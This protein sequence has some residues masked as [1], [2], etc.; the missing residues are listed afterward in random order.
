MSSQTFLAKTLFGI[1]PYLTEEL[2]RLGAREVTPLNRAVSFYGDNAMLYKANLHCRLALNILKPIHVFKAK[3]EEQFYNLVR[4][5]RWEDYLTIQQTF[6]IDAT[7]H[8]EVFRHS[9]YIALKAK[10]AIAD[11]FRDKTGVRPSVNT[12]TPDVKLNL[13]ISGTTC[14][15]S[16]DSSG[17]SLHKRGYRR[18]HTDAPINEVLAAAMVVISGWQPHQTLLDPFCG[19]G[20]ILI[21]AAQIAAN[22]APGLLRKTFGF[23]NWQDFDKKL[24]ENIRHDAQQAV[25]DEPEARIYGSDISGKAIRIACENVEN[26]HTDDMIRL[27]T[28]PFGQRTPPNPEGGYIITNPPYGER[29]GAENMSAF[30]K[31]IGDK[32]KQDF[33][34]YK[35]YIISSNLETMKSFGLKPTKKWTLFNGGLECTFREYELFKGKLIDKKYPE[36]QS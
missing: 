1:E 15:L 26:A 17:D 36:K 4:A 29:I 25:I 8:S 14:T 12:I 3:N 34:G 9:K 5:I 11:Y 24:W 6:A 33:A 13:H 23:M 30:Y 16:L 19:S 22:V 10:D 28:K 21:E 32:L 2:I 27:L 7:V 31:A 35:V 20:T 18:S